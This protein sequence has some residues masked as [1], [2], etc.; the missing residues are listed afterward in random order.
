MTG[1][2][3]T[4][5][6]GE[7]AHSALHLFHKSISPDK[8]ELWNNT[9]ILIIDEKSFAS[10]ETI[11]KVSTNLDKL[12]RH[13]GGFGGIHLIFCGNLRQLQPVGGLA[14]Y[15]MCHKKPSLFRIHANCYIELNGMHR[16]HQ[17]PVWGK[18]LLRFR[19]GNPSDDDINTINTRV[20]SDTTQKMPYDIRYATLQN[21]D[22]D[23][24]NLGI[25]LQKL[26]YSHD[27][28]RHTNNFILIFCDNI[29]IKKDNTIK[30]FKMHIQLAVYLNQIVNFYKT[31]K[32]VDP[33]NS[34][35]QLKM[36]IWIEQLN[37]SMHLFMISLRWTKKETWL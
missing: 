4:I 34:V 5:I 32:T 1:V 22:K 10:N 13:R 17:D 36:T 14:L 28:F 6:G 24:I 7:T 29:I 18:I 8:I 16:F 35:L 15:K 23:S 9:K 26:K 31:Y 21:S 20:Q 33:T 25:F 11:A 37:L 27:N 30:N 2:A 12:K 19:N 3:A